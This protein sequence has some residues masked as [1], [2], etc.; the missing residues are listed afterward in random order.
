VSRYLR[1][2]WY[3]AAYA[4]EVARVPLARTLLDGPMVLYR[5]EDD[6]P[7]ILADRCPHRFAPLSRGRLVGD[8]I[9]CGYHGLRFD[10]SGACVS[11]PH[12]NAVPAAARV[13]TYPAVER[14]GFVWFWPGDPTHAD[15]AVIPDFSYL[16]QPDQFAVVKGYLH[17]KANYQLVVDNLLDLSHAPFLHPGFAIQGV[18]PEQALA[19]TTTKLIREEGRVI[20]FRLRSGLPPNQPS[21][22]IFG[23]GPEPVDSRSHMTWYPPALLDFDLGSCRPGSLPLDGL[24][25]P[26]AHCITPETELTC[27]YFFA[28]GRNLLRE[29][30]TVGE[31]LL[32]MLDS[33]FRTQDEPM[34]E[35]VQRR[36]GD[37][38]DLDS[39]NPVFLPTDGAPVAA[40]RL[41]KKL[42]AAEHEV[43]ES[44]ASR[45]STAVGG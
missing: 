33:A 4:H 19:A 35:D 12:G 5:K 3:V 28:Q 43:A 31:K 41:L 39:L 21:R 44:S 9:Q 25:L 10:S 36:M 6:S 26:A 45:A 11:T 1:N 40:R 32:G 29:D 42:I 16:S 20:A 17:V 7:V 8:A 18:S 30:P 2:I 34:I 15:A 37:S 23:F 27:H 24:C 13:R 38:S 22:T 14:Y